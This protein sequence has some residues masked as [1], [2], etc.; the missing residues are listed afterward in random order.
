[1]TAI[2]LTC[3]SYESATLTYDFP[4]PK[5]TQNLLNNSIGNGELA[6]Y[7]HKNQ[8]L[9]SNNGPNSAKKSCTDS[10]Q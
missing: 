1:M 10:Q 7:A 8:K 2:V 6:I 5:M 9:N 4:F 3:C